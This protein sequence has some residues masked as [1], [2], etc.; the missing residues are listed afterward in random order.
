MFSRSRQTVS[1]AEYAVRY[2]RGDINEISVFDFSLA[3]SAR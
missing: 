1:V 2:R 3:T